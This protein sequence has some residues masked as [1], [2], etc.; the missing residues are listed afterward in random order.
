VAKLTA[1]QALMLLAQ[2]VTLETPEG[3]DVLLAGGQIVL[4]YTAG[5]DGMLVTQDFT[6]G[7]DI[8]DDAAVPQ[9]LPP[10]Y[11]VSLDSIAPPDTGWQDTKPDVPSGSFLWTRCY[12]VEGG[13]G[14]T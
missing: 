9:V 1:Q 3:F 11:A 7:Y 5:K 8:F 6:A 13:Q 2:G 14:G 10:Q 4:Q 12:T